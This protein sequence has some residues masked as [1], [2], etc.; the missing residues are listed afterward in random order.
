[1]GYSRG[2]IYSADRAR[3][4]GTVTEGVIRFRPDGSALE[5]V[6]SKGS[7]TW[8]MDFDWDNELFFTQATSGDHLNHVVLPENVLVRGK[9]GN[10]ASFKT[11]EDHK[12]SFPLM[13]WKQQ[14]YVQIDVVGGFTAVAGSC[15][16]TGGAWPEKYNGTHFSTE[17]TINIVHHDLLKPAGVTFLATREAGREQTEFLT[18]RDLWFRPIH[19]RVGP[20]GALYVV[21]FYNQAVVHNDTRGPRH[22][23]NNAA[24]RPDRDHYFGRV[25]RV[26][27]NE[28]RKFDDTRLDPAR[29]RQ[30]LKA[31]EHPNG[32]V[33]MTAH[34]LLTERAQ[35][36]IAPALNTL[37]TSQ[38]VPAFTRVHALWLL[39]NLGK[40]DSSLLTAAL[41]DQNAAVRKNAARLAGLSAGAAQRPAVIA[42]ALL[43]RL[44]DPAPRVRLEAIVSLGALPVTQE[45][46]YA[47]VAA[48]PSL[49]DPWSESA[50]VGV[51]AQAPTQFI[52]AALNASE[53][54]P[55]GRLVSELSKRV[56]AKQDAALAAQLTTVAASAPAR[57]NALKVAAL[58]SLEAG[59]KPETVPAWT[60]DLQQALRTLAAA[61]SADMSGAAL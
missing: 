51:A 48:Y 54:E 4:F 45:A 59:L 37:A 8:G 18:S 13:T 46:I 50:V 57:A 26:Q 5:Q 38:T 14:A 60:A 58:M 30:L 49:R 55:F 16:Y 1:G 17:P 39:S 10:A 53:P 20:D 7:N 6:S 2:D 22:G 44:D 21:D 28:A 34:R 43:A 61:S 31:L 41:E 35:D 27:H 11:V 32:W 42:K 47:L 25:W 52:A 12:K 33:R 29:P 15:L 36:D 23:A 3:R 56:A 19:V 40:A 9:V 24:V